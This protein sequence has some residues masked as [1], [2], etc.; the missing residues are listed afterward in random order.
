MEMNEAQIK[1]WLANPNGS[2]VLPMN[3][4]GGE[5]AFPVGIRVLREGGPA[6]VVAGTRVVLVR[7]ASTAAGFR[8][9]SAFPIP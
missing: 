8:I 1:E 7:D 9:L 3:N 6:Q 5:P 4:P 2:R